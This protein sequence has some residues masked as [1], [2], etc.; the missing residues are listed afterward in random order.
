MLRKQTRQRG[1][2]GGEGRE[3]A[4]GAVVTTRDYLSCFASCGAWGPLASTRFPPGSNAPLAAG[5]PL[6]WRNLHPPTPPP[7]SP[8]HRPAR[9]P[10]CTARPVVVAAPMTAPVPKPRLAAAACPPACRGRSRRPW[11][12]AKGGAGVP[13][14][15][16]GPDGAGGGAPS[17]GRLGGPPPRP[18]TGARPPG[19]RHGRRRRAVGRGG[20]PSGAIRPAPLS[21][22]PQSAT[23]SP[24]PPPFPPA[25]HPPP[26]YPLTSLPCFYHIRRPLHPAICPGVSVQKGATPPPPATTPPS[27]HPNLGSR[28]SSAHSLHQTTK[29]R[30]LSPPSPRNAGRPLSTPP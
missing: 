24:P 5:P 22:A 16:R 9:W 23:D 18:L 21:F 8:R 11:L 1:V 2:A 15:Q 13:C 4:E 26:F 27:G 3:G 10:P 14:R 12:T 30:P 6:A 20:S 7:P 29:R 19:S 25:P 17:Q 28:P